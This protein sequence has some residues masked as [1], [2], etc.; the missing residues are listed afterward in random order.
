ML[1]EAKDRFVQEIDRLGGHGKVAKLLE[2]ARA[3]VY[4]WCASGNVPMDKLL[5]LQAEGLD[6][7]YVI[8]GHR[9]VAVA[10][11]ALLPEGD[12][13]LLDN[14]HAAPAGVQAGVKTT[15]GA[16]APQAGVG[17]KRKAG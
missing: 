7:T 12:R 5:A 8:T 10:P 11:Q 4:N 6:A 15:L 17:K 3:T 9:S 13:I 16:F 1:D 2:V 14:Y